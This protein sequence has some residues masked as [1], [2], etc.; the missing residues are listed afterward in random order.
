MGH[1]VDETAPDKIRDIRRQKF[2]EQDLPEFIKKV[3]TLGI[4]FEMV[5]K[6]FPM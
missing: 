1:F 3:R 5:T 4:K 6:S 2:F